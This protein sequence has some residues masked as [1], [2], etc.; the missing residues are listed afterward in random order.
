MVSTAPIRPSYLR[1]FRLANAFKF[2]KTPMAE[3]IELAVA[4]LVKV[5][6][7]ALIIG[8]LAVAHHGFERT[9]ED[10]DILYKN[11]DVDILKRL[12]KYFKVVRRASNG[13]YEMRHKTT[14]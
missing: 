7:G 10:L 3:A 13:W 11:R 9:T 2:K 8:G 12:G 14:G 6:G 4:D 5:R 1:L